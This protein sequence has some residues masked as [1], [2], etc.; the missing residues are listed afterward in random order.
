M[1]KKRVL[2]IG[3]EPERMIRLQRVLQSM[4]KLGID[5][6]VLEPV[7]KPRGRPR[8]LKG[9][10]RYLTITFQILLA[11]ADIY[12]FFNVPDNVGLPLTLKRGTLVY[13]VRAP[14]AAVLRETFGKSPLIFL[15]KFIERFMT[16]KADHVV[17]VNRMLAERAV[18]WGARSVR[19]IPN[20]PSEDFG[21][22]R[23]RAETRK[24]LGI[25]DSSVVLYLGKLSK[26]EGVDLLMEVIRSATRLT[27][28]VKFLVVGAGPQESQF[29]RFVERE[30]L[31]G[32]VVM[33]GWI[34]H[35]EVA[36]LIQAADLCLLPRP[37]DSCSP[38]IGPES[39]WKAGEYLSLGKPVLAPR[40]GG[41]ATAPF[42]VI[43]VDPSEMAQ[44]VAEFFR[45][46]ATGSVQPH[47]RWPES[48]RRLERLYRSLGAL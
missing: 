27:P 20:Y 24:E 3:T 5:V 14:W 43:A 35:E 28:K 36:N 23:D 4:R 25:D 44:A 10:I 16:R 41:F 18:T 26:V 34:P 6:R 29:K 30:G 12:H 47:P 48:H 46:P 21:P 45:R 8:I 38:F 33:T 39:I 42:P 22:T 13:D 17:C 1:V 2:L 31:E 7:T 9:M 37:W 11:R 15:A 19:V 40:M 32:R